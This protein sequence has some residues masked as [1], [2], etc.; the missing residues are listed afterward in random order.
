MQVDPMKPTLKAPGTINLLTLTYDETLS[1]SAFNLN[2]R[3]YN[4]V[5]ELANGGAVQVE[6]Y[7]KCTRS[8]FLFV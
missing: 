2:L 6:P 3:R 8:A 7:V 5:N 1:R 4:E